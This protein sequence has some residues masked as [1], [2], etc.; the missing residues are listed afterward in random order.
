MS[1]LNFA[2]VC[3]LVILPIGCGIL[4]G[5]VIDSAL[6]LRD[7]RRTGHASGCPAPSGW[8]CTC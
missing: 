4:A 3:L 7:L 6:N 8:R 2:G 1:L 5:F